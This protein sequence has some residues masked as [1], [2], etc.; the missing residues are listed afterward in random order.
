MNKHKHSRGFTLVELL[1]AIAIIGMLASVVLVS[2]NSAR[3]K[4]RDA[5]RI[6]DVH[7]IQLALENYYDTNGA[8]P[9]QAAD[10]A[11]PA[12][13]FP[14]GTVPKDPNGTSNYHYQ[15]ATG[16]TYCLGTVLENAHSALNNS[17]AACGGAGNPLAGLTCT[18]AGK[19]YCL[20]P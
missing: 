16:A 11:P 20:T 15:S 8:Y 6:A 10:A 17:V 12:A 9:T 18:V 14:S 19:A 5:R 7:S 13:T 1:V 3:A 2:L 4:A